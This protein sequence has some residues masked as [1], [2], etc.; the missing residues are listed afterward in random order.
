[1]TQA[2]KNYR[3]ADRLKQE[4][5]QHEQMIK[6]QQENEALKNQNMKNM[7]RSNKEEALE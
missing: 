5:A 7:V 6:I 2:E 4:R 1:M 3:E